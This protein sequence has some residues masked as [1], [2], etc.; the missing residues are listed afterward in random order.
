MARR[1]FASSRVGDP[2][3]IVKGSLAIAEAAYFFPGA[4][5]MLD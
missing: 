4:E 1:L 2:V 5:P 3:T